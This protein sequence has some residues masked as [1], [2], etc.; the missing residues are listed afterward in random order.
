MSSVSSNV[1]PLERLLDGLASLNG[2]KASRRG[3]A[4][5]RYDVDVTV[6]SLIHI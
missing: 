4:G 1:P 6:L 3:Q 5:I 2:L